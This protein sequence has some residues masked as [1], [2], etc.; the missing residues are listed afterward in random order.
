M[1]FDVLRDVS[2]GYLS[3]GR[4]VAPAE[5][6]QTMLA[7]LLRRRTAAD[8]V[9]TEKARQVKARFAAMASHYLF[10]PDFCNPPSG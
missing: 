9:G 2:I 8:Q 6:A 1:G 7:E 10:E 5:L 4:H 3:L